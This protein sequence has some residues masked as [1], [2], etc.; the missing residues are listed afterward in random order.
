MST[1][2]YQELNKETHAL[3]QGLGKSAGELMKSFQGLHGASMHGGALDEKTKELIA[4]AIAIKAQ[5]DRCIGMHVAAA[6][7]AGASREE[8][9]DTIGVAVM[10]G[11]G[12]SLMYGVDALKAVDEMAS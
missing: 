7:K 11:G 10:M 2:S 12:P 6:L 4:L 1:S 8:I 3:M 5:C 9:V